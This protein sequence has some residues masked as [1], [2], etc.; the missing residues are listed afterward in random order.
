M[1]YYKEFTAIAKEFGL[2]GKDLREFAEEK[3]KA[4]EEKEK[5]NKI[6]DREER[7]ARRE[8]E[9]L[10]NDNL[11]LQIDLQERGHNPGNNT[12]DRS[13][14]N[15]SIKVRKYDSKKEKIDV[16][17]DYF[18]SVMDIKGYEEKDWPTQLMTKLTG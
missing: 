13:T 10:K 5:Q 11:K 6:T 18:E 1:D 17:L 9:Q 8:M 4:A 7:S 3:V 14:P 15:E 16:Y 12:N 2:I